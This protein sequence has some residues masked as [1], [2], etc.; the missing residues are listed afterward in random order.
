MQD[1]KGH[2]RAAPPPSGRNHPAVDP[3]ARARRR[4]LAQHK[5]AHLAYKLKFYEKKNVVKFV[6]IKEIF[7]FFPVFSRKVSKFFEKN[8]TFKIP[9]LAL[10]R[11]FY[12]AR[13]TAPY[14]LRRR[15]RRPARTHQAR[16]GGGAPWRPRRPKGAGDGRDG[17]AYLTCHGR[18]ERP[19]T[20]LAPA[21][22]QCMA[23]R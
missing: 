11:A 8:R 10:H 23:R 20:A 22:H 13:R 9:N 3:S 12:P 2:C 7:S 5:H 6:K 15:R 14:L 16:H 1:C 21:A 19:V 4:L 18:R 17:P